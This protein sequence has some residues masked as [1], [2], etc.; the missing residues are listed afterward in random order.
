MWA[1]SL[2]KGDFIG[3]LALEKQKDRQNYGKV[4]YYEVNDRRIPREK[5]SIFIGENEAGKVLSG[6]YSPLIKKPIGTLYLENEF[7]EDRLSTECF[8]DV[9][10]NLVPVNFSKPVL[11]YPLPGCSNAQGLCCSSGKQLERLP[12]GGHSAASGDQVPFVCST[13]ALWIASWM[14]AL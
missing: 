6:G 13:S 11:T 14:G 1:V 8:A 3:R 5:S 4:L 2:D 10:G 9:R 7:L 12:A